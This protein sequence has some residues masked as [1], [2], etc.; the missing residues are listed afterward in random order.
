VTIGG[1]GPLDPSV[2][3]PHD[4]DFRLPGLAYPMVPALGVLACLVIVAQMRPVVLAIGGGILFV[5]MVWYPAYARTRAVKP[6][7]VGEA[8]AGYDTVCV[9]ATRSTAVAQALFGSIPE[10]IG[11]KSEGTVALARGRQYWPRSVSQGLID[12]LSR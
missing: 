3:V 9:G 2:P 10:E 1:N 12:W 5:G 6:S 4:P 8:I 7:L 11:E